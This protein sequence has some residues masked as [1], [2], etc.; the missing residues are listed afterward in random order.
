[1]VSDRRDRNNE[2]DPLH[3]SSGLSFD[4]WNWRTFDLPT[5]VEDRTLIE[6]L[7]A[8]RDHLDELLTRKGDYALAKGR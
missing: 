1:M 3:L 7:T 2:P 6:E 5:V 8:Y 4:Q